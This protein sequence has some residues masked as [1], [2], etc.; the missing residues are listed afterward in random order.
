MSRK[1]AAALALLIAVALLPIPALA[2]PTSMLD[3][4]A[5][6]TTDNTTDHWKWDKDSK[7]LTLNGATIMGHIIFP[8]NSKVQIVGKNK[9]DCYRTDGDASGI[10]VVLPEGEEAGVLA[11]GGDIFL[12][13]DG[14]LEISQ[15][16]MGKH[17]VPI[18]AD[19]FLGIAETNGPTVSIYSEDDK[20]PTIAGDVVV[21]SGDISVESKYNGVMLFYNLTVYNGK[22]DGIGGR[23]GKGLGNIAV[24]G[25]KVSISVI[26]HEDEPDE[27]SIP[28]YQ[29][30]VAVSGSGELWLFGSNIGK[31]AAYLNEVPSEE[32]M[33]VLG[34]TQCNDQN[35]TE[36]VAWRLS[37]DGYHAH[38]GE[39]LAR[40]IKI[41]AAGSSSGDDDGP[42]VGPPTG[43]T[44]NT[45]NTTTGNPTTGAADFVS[46]ATAAALMALLGAAALLRK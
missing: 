42:I 2:A 41:T 37:D 15:L 25:G 14:I 34:S 11:K 46:T 1:L 3:F 32:A 33:A 10:R 28:L 40:T 31:G 27:D 36:N 35:P 38:I 20:N 29:E 43:D 23:Y 21:Y 24:F 45:P 4:T 30:K 9:I 5:M 19:I 13:G 12:L 17:M 16:G 7:T 6:E 18:Q 22:F 26:H 39:E 8:H 44:P